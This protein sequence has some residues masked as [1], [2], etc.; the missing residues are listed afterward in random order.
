M[1]RARKVDVVTGAS[2]SIGRATVLALA[3]SGA[4][5]VVVSRSAAGRE[6]TRHRGAGLPGTVTTR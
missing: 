1:S 3:E 4:T 5:V 2:G 6:E